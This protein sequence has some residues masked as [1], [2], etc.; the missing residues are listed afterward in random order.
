MIVEEK[1]EETIE[2]NACPAKPLAQPPALHLRGL[3]LLALLA[4]LVGA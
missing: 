2:Q 1:S 4:A 3:L